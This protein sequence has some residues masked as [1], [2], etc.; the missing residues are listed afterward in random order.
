MKRENDFRT[1]SLDGAINGSCLRIVRKLRSCGG[2][3]SNV[4]YRVGMGFIFN[5]IK[6]LRNSNQVENVTRTVLQ[7]PQICSQYVPVVIKHTVTVIVSFFDRD[8][9]YLLISIKPMNE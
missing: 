8:R 7:L 1:S 3:N 9:R 6:R 4:H 5:G 2:Q